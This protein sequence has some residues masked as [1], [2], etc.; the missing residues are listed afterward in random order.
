MCNNQFLFPF[1]LK[2]IGIIS[3]VMLS[4]FSFLT[5]KHSQI[6]K[7]GKGDDINSNNQIID[8]KS[9]TIFKLITNFYIVVVMCSI[10]IG[11]SLNSDVFTNQITLFII[12]CCITTLGIKL[13]YDLKNK[14]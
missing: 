7:F 12:T 8:K 13:G 6:E 10:I 5:I 3:L 14:E 4:Y 1:V 9:K 2:I 11:N